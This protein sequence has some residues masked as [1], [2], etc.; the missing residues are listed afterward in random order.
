M[1]LSIHLEPWQQTTRAGHSGVD[2]SRSSTPLDTLDVILR[3]SASSTLA[4]T[5]YSV[6]DD[7]Q[8]SL[9]NLNENI[10]VR[11]P[12]WLG[13][14]QKLKSRFVL[15]GEVALLA[16]PIGFIVLAVTAWGFD[17]ELVSA[18]GKSF[19]RGM[20]FGPTLFPLAFAALGGRSMRNIALWKAQ[21]GSTIG[22]GTLRPLHS[23]N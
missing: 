1:P 2:N 7:N 5:M 18:Q 12:G 22:V 11:F 8:D 16:L 4:D 6:I 10:I 21:R 9:P 17:G 15:F 20:L 3:W 19:Q 14:P 23:D 13:S